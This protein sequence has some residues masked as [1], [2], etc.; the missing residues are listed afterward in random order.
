MV[1]PAPNTSAWI[2]LSRL[3]CA[4]SPPSRVTSSVVPGGSVGRI[5]STSFLMRSATVT[6]LASRARVIARP[7]LGRPLRDEKLVS[8]A[9]PSSMVATCDSR[10]SSLPR[11]LM[12]I[13][14]KSAGRSMRPTRRMLLSS[15]VPRILPTGAVAFCARSA[16]TTSVTETSYSRSFCERISTDSSRLSEPFTFTVA[17]PGMPRKRSASWSSARREICACVCVVELSA[18][19][20]MGCAAGSSRCRM[21]SRISVGSL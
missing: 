10:T 3:L 1:S 17:T 15:S 9:K 19:C 4:S 2:T 18:S 7:T 6:V 12:T 13:C 21:G 5:S 11:R 16:A 8:S 20:T 14:P